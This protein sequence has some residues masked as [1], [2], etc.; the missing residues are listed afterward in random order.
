LIKKGIT[1]EIIKR[2]FTDCRRLRIRTF[3]NMLVNLPQETEKDLDDILQLL[4]EIKATIVSINI[5]TPYPGTEIF[6]THN[7]G[8]T[9]DD[10]PNLMK[11]PVELMKK[12]PKKYRFANHSVDIGNWVIKNNKW[13]YLRMAG[14]PIKEFITQ[15]F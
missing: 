5:F 8:I 2:V 3:A 12:E 10:Y 13:N 14:I 11:S 6:E 4:D 1:I 15:K 7:T 9:K